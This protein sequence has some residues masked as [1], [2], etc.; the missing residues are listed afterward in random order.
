VTTND[1]DVLL[2]G[3]AEQFAVGIEEFVLTGDIVA[4]QQQMMRKVEG[5]D[6]WFIRMARFVATRSKDGSKQVGAVVV[7]ASHVVLSTG[8]NGFP[9]GAD[10]SEELWSRPVKYDRVVHAETNAII[11]AARSGASLM[12]ATMYLGC[13]PCHDCAN[14]IIQSGIQLVVAQEF[15]E[16]NPFTSDERWAKSI[17]DGQRIMQEAGVATRFI[18]VPPKEMLL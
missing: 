17:E 8:F 1:E 13:M 4:A 14:D 12:G 11:A 18:D 6:E 16:H 5:W 2:D 10:E 3:L 7:D 15:N 9:R